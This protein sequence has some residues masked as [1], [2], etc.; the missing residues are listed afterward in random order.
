[1]PSTLAIAHPPALAQVIPDPV[2]LPEVIAQAFTTAMAE[3]VNLIQSPLVAHRFATV[4]L[5][6]LRTNLDLQACTPISLIAVFVEAAEA[7]LDLSGQNE[8]H[9]IP[10]RSYDKAGRVT[11]VE[12]TMQL[13]YVGLVKLALAHPDVLDVYADVVCANDGW[14]Y[15]GINRLPE[16][17]YPGGFAPRGPMLGFYSTAELSGSRARCLQMSVAEMKEHAR[18][19]SRNAEKKVWSDGPGGGFQGMALKTMLR[20]LCN[21][22]LI[23]MSARVAEL[24]Y[25]MDVVEGVVLPEPE[26]DSAA[27]LAARAHEAAKPLEEHISDMWDT[28][29]EA[30]TAVH[31]EPATPQAAA[32]DPET[33]PDAGGGRRGGQSLVEAISTLH[34]VHGGKDA[35]WLT[36]YWGKVCRQAAVQNC[37]QLQLAM[38]TDLHKRVRDHYLQGEASTLSPEEREGPEATPP[39][40]DAPR[41]EDA[42]R[43]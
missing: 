33:A 34:R 11:K 20:K 7:G 23:P 16:H 28:A 25:K 19:Y 31:R 43:P 9:I 4:A 12:A 39:A 42:T 21:P 1:M 10:Y 36:A 27:T 15:R 5:T 3:V 14:V 38:L 35:G 17:R 32:P 2:G 41:E 29:A 24:L 30:C 40:D 8:C 22:K 18:K 13:G 37:T 6:Q 26:P